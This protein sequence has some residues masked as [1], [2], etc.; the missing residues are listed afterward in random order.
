LE[1]VFPP[2]LE[3]VPPPLYPLHLT[4]V[5]KKPSQ[6]GSLMISPK[7]FASETSLHVEPEGFL[8]SRVYHPFPIKKSKSKRNLIQVQIKNTA[9]KVHLDY[10]F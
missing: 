6:L 9:T 4:V 2:K 5:N 8:S 1:K 3:A 7:N 10:K